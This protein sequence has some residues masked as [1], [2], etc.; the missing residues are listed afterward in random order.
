ME[1]YKIYK[2]V[3]SSVN[4]THGHGNNSEKSYN[5]YIDAKIKKGMVYVEHLFIDNASAQA[6]TN[7]IVYITSPSIPAENAI[8]IFRST[9]AVDIRQ[10]YSLL[11]VIPLTLNNYL[12]TL[13]NTSD[14]VWSE[15][16]TL[17]TI[18]TPVKNLD[19]HNDFILQVGNNQ[20]GKIANADIT[21][22][23]IGLIF[24][25]FEPDD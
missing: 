16:V 11:K 10:R 22:Y 1:N 6:G 17:N 14:F 3:L 4:A 2:V 5:L 20:Y 21:S 12:T 24:V 25:D 19:L 18:G 23:T 13:D 15:P 9:G 7:G 8:S